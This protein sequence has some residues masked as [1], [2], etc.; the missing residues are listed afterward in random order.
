[1]FIL[2]GKDV[3]AAS[4]WEI[5]YL[6]FLLLR[7]SLYSFEKLYI[8]FTSFAVVV[9]KLLLVNPALAASWLD[10]VSSANRWE[11]MPSHLALPLE[12]WTSEQEN[13]H[14]LEGLEF[15]WKYFWGLSVVCRRLRIWDDL[16]RRPNNHKCL[17][18]SY[19]MLTPEVSLWYELIHW[20]FAGIL[21]GLEGLPIL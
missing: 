17:L 19:Y 20:I 8:R 5:I 14:L 9:V 6:A 7:F 4:W 15:E 21:W 2:R 13:G 1:M 10:S 3:V 18:S 11:A 12:S 16:Y